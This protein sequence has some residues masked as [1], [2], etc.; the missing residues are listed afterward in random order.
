MTDR[1]KSL[2]GVQYAN[3]DGGKD[4]SDR[5][6]FSDYLLRYFLTFLVVMQRKK[7]KSYF[8]ALNA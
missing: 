4:S 3:E 6:S 7:N 5:V 8:V 1:V 2:Y